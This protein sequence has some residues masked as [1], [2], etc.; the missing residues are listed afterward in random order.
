MAVASVDDSRAV[1]TGLTEVYRLYDDQG[2]LLYVG[3][4]LSFAQRMRLHRSSSDWW[5]KVTR[6]EIERFGTRD[7]ASIQEGEYIQTLAPTHNRQSGGFTSTEGRKQT[8]C[9]RLQPSF[10]AEIDAFAHEHAMRRNAFFEEA[11]RFYMA[12]KAQDGSHDR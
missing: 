9:V 2:E 5:H 11:L 6:I 12:V 3:M 4:S 1:R 10:L 8:V 7:E